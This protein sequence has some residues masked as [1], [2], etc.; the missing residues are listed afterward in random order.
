MYSYSSSY[1]TLNSTISTLRTFFFIFLITY[2][3]AWVLTMQIVTKAAKEK[4]YDD[5]GGKLWFIGLFG[6]IFTPPI[7]VAALPDKRLQDSSAA[8]TSS[9]IAPATVDELPDL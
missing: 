6:L 2:I 7:I 3:I 5:L 9:Q 4:G 1:D 8:A